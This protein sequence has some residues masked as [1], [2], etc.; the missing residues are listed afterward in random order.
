MIEYL[1][2]WMYINDINDKNLLK[3][4]KII[5]KNPQK[6]VKVFSQ[7]AVILYYF[8]KL[9]NNQITDK[10]FFYFWDSFWDLTNFVEDIY[11]WTDV[12]YY[13]QTYAKLD[14][15]YAKDN[16]FIVDKIYKNTVLENNNLKIFYI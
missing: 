7:K 15:N 13:I 16:I 4:W 6:T 11:L 5:E 1:E 8:H 10:Q 9:I 12:A 14:K 3:I 2:K